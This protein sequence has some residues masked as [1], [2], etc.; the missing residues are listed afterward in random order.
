M[1][2]VCAKSE[3]DADYPLKVELEDG[4]I[5]AVYRVGEQVYA[6]DD[7]CSH[8]DASLSDGFVEGYD[9]V[10]PF[11]MGRFDIR[12]GEATGEPCHL[13]IKAYTLRI[14]GDDVYLAPGG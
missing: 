3:I 5:L 1:K 2:P 14:E 12:T 4:S 9:V 11:H 7:L 8:G 10:C 6:T 13:A